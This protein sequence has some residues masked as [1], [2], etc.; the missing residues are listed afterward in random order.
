MQYTQVVI[1]VEKF[2][3]LKTLS[4][5][6]SFWWTP[7]RLRRTGYPEV[8]LKITFGKRLAHS[9]H[10]SAILPMTETCGLFARMT[11]FPAAAAQTWS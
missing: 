11:L 6:Q 9:R 5:C 10:L 4:L 2:L 3:Y 1:L 8:S 7:R